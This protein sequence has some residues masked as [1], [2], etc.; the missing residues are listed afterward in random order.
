MGGSSSKLHLPCSLRTSGKVCQCPHTYN[1]APGTNRTA[2]AGMSGPVPSS[3]LSCT[4]VT[5]LDPYHSTHTSFRLSCSSCLEHFRD[6]QKT[7]CTQ[8]PVLRAP[9]SLPSA[10]PQ[11]EGE[12]PLP[13]TLLCC[14]LT[15]SEP[16][17]SAP[18]SSPPPTSR[19]QPASPSSSCPSTHGGS[20]VQNEAAVFGASSPP[21]PTMCDTS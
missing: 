18:A 9:Q 16:V 4:L 11:P 14:R 13:F 2:R 5:T 12:S 6:P 7:Q 17:L 1:K 15:G 10:P 20:C 21:H 19:T 8:D 3:S